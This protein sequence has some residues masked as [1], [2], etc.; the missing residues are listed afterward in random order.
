MNSAIE[1]LLT[2]RV[3][4]V[5]SRNVT[6]I[7]ASKTMPE[8]ATILTQHFIS[9]APVVGQQ[10]E[11]VGILSATDFVRCIAE[12]AR[13]ERETGE[14]LNGESEGR[15]ACAVEATD[16]VTS[17][18]SALLQTVEANQ[19]LMEAARLMC[20]SHIHRLVVLDAQHH[21]V[22]MLTSLDIVAAVINA[23]EE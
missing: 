16:S 10:G 22:G 12:S 6:S 1:R 18:M 4:D 21:P 8:G 5:M 2:L 3:S 23:V 15:H 11:C 19:P 13:V 14:K 9:G 7:E 17:H 20:Q